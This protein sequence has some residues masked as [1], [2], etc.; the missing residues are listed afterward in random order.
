MTWRAPR[1]AFADVA[2]LQEALEVPGAG[3]LGAGAPRPGRPGG[4]ARVHV[5]A[6][7][8]WRRRRT[9]PGIAEAADR[10]ARALRQGERDRGARRLRLRRHLLHGDPG[11]ARCAA[12][13]ATSI[14]FLPSR[15]TEGYGVAVSTV[16]APRRPR[17][18]ACWSAWTAARPRSPP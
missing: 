6:T 2:A 10:L 1:V 18:R 12:A 17:R 13:A 16:E 8:R 4:G 3:R 7:A 5:L 15:F 9:C 11:R 14:P